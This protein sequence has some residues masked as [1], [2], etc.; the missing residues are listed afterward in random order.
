MESAKI[1]HP[2]GDKKYSNINTAI[3]VKPLDATNFWNIDIN[4]TCRFVFKTAR[5]VGLFAVIQNMS[6]R[7]DGKECVDYV[8]VN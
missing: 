4:K 2:H 6:L 7:R 1:C 5:H 8:Q 3:I